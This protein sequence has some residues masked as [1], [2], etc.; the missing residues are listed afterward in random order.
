MWLFKLALMSTP[1]ILGLSEASSGRADILLAGVL[2]LSRFME[3]GGFQE[4][5]VSERGLR[6]GLALRDWQKTSA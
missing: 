6:Y 4:A 5:M 1:E 2:I 3:R